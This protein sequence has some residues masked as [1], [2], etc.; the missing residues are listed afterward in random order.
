MRLLLPA[1]LPPP[2]SPLNI[3]AELRHPCVVA[4]H[5]CGPWQLHKCLCNG[6]TVVHATPR[7]P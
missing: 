5:G 7:H 3:P 6:P 2:A 1:P 4:I